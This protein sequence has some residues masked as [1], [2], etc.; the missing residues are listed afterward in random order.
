MKN[1]FLKDDLLKKNVLRKVATHVSTTECQERGLPYVHSLWLLQI[2]Q[3]NQKSL[4]DRVVSAEISDKDM[5][6]ELLE[7]VKKTAYTDYVGAT[8]QIVHTCMVIHQNA[9]N[10]SLNN[11]EVH[12]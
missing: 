7:I 1:D 12:L 6:P 4:I 3:E 5:N 10:H 9:Q 2:S 11:A 8:F